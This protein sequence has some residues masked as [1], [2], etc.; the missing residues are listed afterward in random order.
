MSSEKVLV[1]FKG[2]KIPVSLSTLKEAYQEA[3]R[4]NREEVIFAVPGKKRTR[5]VILPREKAKELLIKSEKVEPSELE[6][7]PP[8]PPSQIVLPE[9]VLQKIKQKEEVEEEE[10]TPQSI[11]LTPKR[12]SKVKYDEEVETEYSPT[13]LDRV[14]QRVKTVFEPLF[15]ANTYSEVDYKTKYKPRLALKRK[16]LYKPRDYYTFYENYAY[17]P[18]YTQVEDEDFAPRDREVLGYSPQVVQESY[19]TF[20]YATYGLPETYIDQYAPEESVKIKPVTEF[21]I[22]TKPKPLVVSKAYLILLNK[23]INEVT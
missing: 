11:V 16:I 14:R 18:K 1:E 13:F 22:K 20:T 21:E 9:E 17:E 10:V 7:I 8:S 19:P 15:S 3:L 4:K 12:E 5:I 23:L 6:K 2:K